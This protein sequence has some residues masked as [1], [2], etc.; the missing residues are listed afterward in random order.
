[1]AKRPRSKETLIKEILE[2]E[3]GWTIDA[4]SHRAMLAE[5]MMV[6]DSRNLVIRENNAQGIPILG[7]IR[8]D[9]KNAWAA[10]KKAEDS[11]KKNVARGR[12]RGLAQA[13]ATVQSPYTRL[14]GGGS[15][16]AY[17]REVEEEARR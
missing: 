7:M 11:D 10:W 3:M 17:V 13:L 4:R 15:W 14:H 5:I 1:M 6:V 16:S 12:V 2:R 9:L 8:D